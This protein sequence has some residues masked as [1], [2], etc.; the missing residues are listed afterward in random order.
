MHL[1]MFSFEEQFC[2]T[3]VT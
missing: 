1:L 2:D 3:T